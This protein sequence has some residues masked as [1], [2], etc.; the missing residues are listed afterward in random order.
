VI[1][2]RGI[3]ILAATPPMKPIPSV[4]WRLLSAG[5]VLPALR[6]S[7]WCPYIAGVGMGSYLI[8][9]LKNSRKRKQVRWWG[10]R[11]GNDPPWNN[12]GGSYTVCMGTGDGMILSF[13]VFKEKIESGEKCQTIRKFSPVQYKRFLNCWKKRETTGRYNL[14]W[15]NPRNGGKR[16]KDVVPSDC[17]FL[18][19]FCGGSRAPFLRTV[20]KFKQACNPQF[21][22]EIAKQDGF[23]TSGEMWDWFK[24]NYGKDMY[25]S[26][27]MVI[28]WQPWPSEAAGC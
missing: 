18:I 22:E 23:S 10:G 11:Y 1:S 2:R 21:H 16:I 20:S 4:K 28:R 8:G 17:P 7:P 27:F 5:G 13:S 3:V 14:F 24:E 25:Q 9:V 6:V 12:H 19:T 15:H 26:K